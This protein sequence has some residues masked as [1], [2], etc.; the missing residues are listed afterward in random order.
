MH[1]EIPQPEYLLAEFPPTDEGG[2]GVGS[3]LSH[4]EHCNLRLLATEGDN[5]AFYIHQPSY[6]P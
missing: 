2:G 6:S 5:P 4:A 1:R 3:V